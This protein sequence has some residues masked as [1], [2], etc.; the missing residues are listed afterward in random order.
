[1]SKKISLLLFVV[2]ITTLISCSSSQKNTSATVINTNI[3]QVVGNYTGTIP[4]A[5]CEGIEYHLTLNSDYTYTKSTTYIGK[6]ATANIQNGKFSISNNQIIEL[7]ENGAPMDFLKI[8]DTGMLLLDKNGNLIE[9]SLADKYLLKINHKSSEN[10]EANWQK[11]LLQKHQN[12]VDFY[13]IAHEPSWSLEMDFDSIIRFKTMDGVEI[14]VPA[15]EPTLAQDHNVKRY[16]AVTESSEIIIQIIQG[17]CTDTMSGQIF[18]YQV[19]VAYKKTT[20]KDYTSL[21]GCGMYVPDFRL[22]NIWAIDKVYGV[23]I[24]PSDF[25]NKV[26]TLEIFT[27]EQRV[28]GFDGCNSFRGK[29]YNEENRL[30]FGPMASTM[31][32][33]LNNADISHKINTALTKKRLTYTIKNNTFTIFDNHSEIMTL[34]PVD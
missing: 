15:V 20:E 17:N 13:A 14:N 28:L 11:L 3:D 25:V 21:D 8:T 26:P 19:T 4:C 31:M 29:I 27:S 32:A 18:P 12:G 22:H 23:E 16:R 33:C 34:K 7:D 2:V 9:G 6:S 24:N 1:M 10:Q 5:D 30:Y